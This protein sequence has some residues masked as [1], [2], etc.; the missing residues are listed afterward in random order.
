MNSKSIFNDTGISKMI[1][2]L[3]N[4]KSYIK[5]RVSLRLLKYQLR[6]LESSD[7]DVA[8]VA[9]AAIE[10]IT[11]KFTSKE[12]ELFQKIE[13]RRKNLLASNDSISYIDY[14]AGKS[15]NP[16]SLNAAEQGVIGKSTVAKI[17][18]AS[19]SQQRCLF[20]NKLVSKFNPKVVFEMGSCVGIS[21]AYLSTALKTKGFGQLTTM[22]GSPEVA[23]IALETFA[24]LQL[25]AKV[26]VGS[27]QS[28]LVNNFENSPKIDFLF[29]DGHHDGDAMLQYFDS[30]IPYLAN[31]AIVVFD[32]V[33]WSKSMADA[34]Q[35][36]ILHSKVAISINCG[37]AGIV[38]LDERA[39]TKK[40]YKF[41][42]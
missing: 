17:A 13:E 34:F 39:V 5:N 16:R 14:G 9:E 30:A 22:E 18:L 11:N 2:K 8:Q 4:V 33:N 40:H 28:E 10:T 21:G 29:N 23:K 31:K 15:N 6:K 24:I 42:M 1:K 19:K 32:D 38:I 7:V 25:E 41:L 12:R 37:W 35:K 27:F 3:K 36:I 20:L 26:R